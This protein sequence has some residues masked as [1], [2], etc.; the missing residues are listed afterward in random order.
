MFLAWSPELFYMIS[1]SNTAKEE[2]KFENLLQ[3]QS[4][5]FENR[6]RGNENSGKYFRTQ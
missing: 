4:E 3:T 2:I 6:W 1:I 5:K